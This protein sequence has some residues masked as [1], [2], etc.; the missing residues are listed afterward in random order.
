[1]KCCW[2]TS[3]VAPQNLWKPFY[4]FLHWQEERPRLR[5]KEWLT[6][7]ELDE[8]KNLEILKLE[9]K[10]QHFGTEGEEALQICIK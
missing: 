9:R 7:L 6:P 1:M 8:T 2:T 10:L 5:T 4:C 3:T